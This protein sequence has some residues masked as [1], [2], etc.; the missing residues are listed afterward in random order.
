MSYEIRPRIRRLF[1]LGLRRRDLLRQDIDSELQFHLEARV[2][3]L[4]DRGVP[5]EAARA[6]A[7]RR[8][9]AT[10]HDRRA[11]LYASAAR[12]DQIM[13]TREWLDDVAHDARYAVRG[14]ARRPG[15]TAVAIITLAV[16]I[17][18]NTAIFS[19]V[20]AL[21]LR[22]LPFPAPERLM[23][24][25]LSGPPDGVAG[26]P[27]SGRDDVV[28]RR[29]HPWS[30]AKFAIFRKEQ[31]SFSEVALWMAQAVNV[32]E[33]DAERVSAEHVTARYLSTLGLLPGAGSDF[34]PEIDVRG[35]APPIILISDGYWQRRFNSDPS[36]VGRTIAVDGEAHEIIGVMPLGFR[37]LS[38]T[39]ELL[40]PITRQPQEQLDELWSLS[41]SQVGRLKQ[42]VTPEQAEREA[43]VLGTRIHE[44]TPMELHPGDG[45][46]ASW[47]AVARPLDATRVS[48][49]VRQSLIVLSCAVGF[50]LLIACVNL[51]NLLLGRATV[52]RREIAV[53]LALG[54][55]RRRLVRLLL[56]ESV[57]LA[58]LGGTASVA[59]AWWGTRALSA[60]NPLA[61]L[62]AQNL[63]GLGVVGFEQIRLDTPALLFTFGVSVAVGILFGLVP[64][65]QATKPQ[66]QVQLKAGEDIPLASGRLRAVT[67]RRVLVVA[68]VALAIML[69][70][71]AGLMIRSL[72]R[73]LGV[74]TGFDARSVLT[75]RL[76]VPPGE[77]PRDSLA[78]FYGELLERVRALPGVTDA[79]LADCPPLTGGCNGTVIAFPD[80]PE[81]SGGPPASI[82]VHWV[83]PGWFRTLRIPLKAGR[84]FAESDRAGTPRVLVISEAAARKYWPN[85]NPIGKRAAVF[86]GGFHEG[87]TVIGVV[88]DVRFGT[89]DS[90]PV[91]DAYI[92]YLQS[93][94]GRMMVFARTANDPLGL[95]GVAREAVRDLSPRYPAYDVRTMAS[96]VAVAS[97]QARLS[98]TLLSLFAGVAL[99]LAVMG[100]Y[101][102]MS[103]AVA[104]RT[105]EIGVRIALGAS[106]G[107]VLRM[108]VGEGTGLAAIGIMIGL[109]GALALTRL[110]QSL[111]YGVSATDPATYATIVVLLGLA[112]FAASW[113]PARRAAGV[114]PSEALRAG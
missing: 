101:G 107:A 50:V 103:F 84:L 19:A 68:E 95:A 113:W 36:A 33:G 91:P 48:A 85:D 89:I 16:G 98:A 52:R 64:A 5:P 100:I 27:L 8:L 6:E 97:A 83:T 63:A 109:A 88:G 17:G 49:A 71:G 53:R 11:A 57:L 66:L 44:L 2:Q 61:S 56:T 13:A 15:F 35:G 92:S 28:A 31:R 82:G 60:V 39:A 70:A 106:R 30:F 7:L 108:V 24:I 42:G 114:Q 80:R 18:A 55:R 75:M 34:P 99:I 79:G 67:S 62:Q 54:A 46:Q 40:I 21:L 104:Q 77:V 59:V 1:H 74:D 87:A 23:D 32:T 26:V 94:R 73:L 96:R 20:N 22:S 47:S 3:Q 37:G 81:P 45:G 10:T 38:G 112:A 86:Q 111:L 69:L 58:L 90:L 76:N 4:I 29:L 65:L 41:Y 9:G 102:V 12:R 51:A 25:S 110:L 43:I 105:R 14:L 93:P 78:G 72:D